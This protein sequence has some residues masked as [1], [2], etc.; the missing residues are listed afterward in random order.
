MIIDSVVE[1]L[2]HGP[3]NPTR[4]QVCEALEERLDYAIRE[5]YEV[6]VFDSQEHHDPACV[7]LQAAIDEV[8]CRLS[9]IY[10][11]K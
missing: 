7:S 9:I 10:A 8:L 1:D 3:K 6:C 5:G 11:H 4:R 2:W